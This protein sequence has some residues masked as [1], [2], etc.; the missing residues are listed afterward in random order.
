VQEVF[1]GN[2]AI[3]SMTGYVSIYSAVLGVAFVYLASQA[4][5][6]RERTKFC[7][8]NGC[9]PA[10]SVHQKWYLFGLDNVVKFTTRSKKHVFLE[11][12][13]ND[14]KA[15]GSSTVSTNMGDVDLLL[16]MSPENA[17]AILASKA[18]DFHVSAR[19]IQAFAPFF[20]DGVAASNGATWAH[21]RAILRP[22]FS[23]AQV[24]NSEVY[25]RHFQELVAIVPNDGST[26][27]LR[28]LFSRLT[29]DVATEITFGESIFSQKSD[30][31]QP[32]RDFDAAFDI[33]SKGVMDRINLGP[34][35]SPCSE[36]SGACR[37]KRNFHNSFYHVRAS[38]S[39]T[40]Q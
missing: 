39:E 27:D 5:A 1:T 19:R 22:S 26:V 34:G 35:K 29:L 30:A 17:K 37:S 9:K 31:P 6:H 8:K 38:N 15:V 21:G 2:I 33:A 3:I 23:K 25:E 11:G 40:L 4:L 13:I 24:S 12:M 36:N 18:D 7:L 20:G 10:P 28:V 14:F 16:T 32:T